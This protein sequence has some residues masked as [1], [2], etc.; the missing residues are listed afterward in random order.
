MRGRLAGLRAG[1]R[2]TPRDAMAPEAAALSSIGA[3][4]ACRGICRIQS[5]L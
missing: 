4:S 3:C 1:A 2:L 5:S